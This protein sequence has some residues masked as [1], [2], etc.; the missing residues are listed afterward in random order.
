MGQHLTA[1]AIKNF[2]VYTTYHNNPKQIKAGDPLPLNLT[3]RAAVLRLI[4]MLAPD[5]IVHLAA[6]N[7]GANERE[8]MQVNAEGARYVAEGAVEVGARLV[9]ISSDIVHNGHNAPYDDDAPPSPINLYG[10]SKAAAEA[11]I[12]ETAPQ[13][14]IVRTSLIYGLDQMDRGT[15]GFVKRLKAKRPL[16]LFN[17]VI[18]QPVWVETLNEALL[19]L[20]EID[21]AGMLNVV[22]AQPLTREEF[23]RRMLGW[24]KINARG[25]LKSGRATDVSQTTPLDLRLTIAKAEQLLQMSFPGVDKV[26]AMHRASL[27]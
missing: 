26:L 4:E 9:H 19:K 18:R 13:T 5:A 1:R 6:I 23:G 17:D 22:G 12:V 27:L 20:V 7:P 14:A 24:W 2:S 21:F 25:L 10:R 16:V 15:A 3:N 8:M 11:A